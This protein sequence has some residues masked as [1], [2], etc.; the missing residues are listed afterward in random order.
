MSNIEF[1]I[2]LY[3]IKDSKTSIHTTFIIVGG[4]LF[5]DEGTKI[6]FEIF[7]IVK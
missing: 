2:L 3:K 5:E 1:D 7:A 6:R 4:G